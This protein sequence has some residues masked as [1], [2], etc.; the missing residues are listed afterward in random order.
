[1]DNV[2][3]MPMTRTLL[4]NAGA[5]IGILLFEPSGMVIFAGML[6]PQVALIVLQHRRIRYLRGEAMPL[7]KGH[8]SQFGLA[9]APVLLAA[10]AQQACI[11]AERMFASFLEEGSIT[12]LSFAFRIVTIPLTLYAMSVL[13]VLFPQF[14]ASWNDDDH[15]GHAAVIRKGLLA[16]LLFLVPVPISALLWPWVFVALQWARRRFAVY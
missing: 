14:S 4:L 6:L 16:T 9:F 11:L 1:M 2:F 10:G 13:S 7:E 15:R 12:M 8:G 3:I 5:I